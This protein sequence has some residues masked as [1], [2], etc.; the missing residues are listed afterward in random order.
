MTVDSRVRSLIRTIIPAV[1]AW[2]ISKGILPEGM[3][4]DTQGLVELV[5]FAGYYTLVRVLE[6]K[7]SWMGWLL[8]FKGSPEYTP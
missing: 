1:I 8:G 2:A 6:A 4:E 5:V 7:W 3:A